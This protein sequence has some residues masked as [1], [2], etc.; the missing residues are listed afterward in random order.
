MAM[1]MAGGRLTT[2]HR[3]IRRRGVRMGIT[4]AHIVQCRAFDKFR[5]K[6]PSERRAHGH[7]H[8]HRAEATQPT[9]PWDHGLA[10]RTSPGMRCGATVRDLEVASRSGVVAASHQNERAEHLPHITAGAL[11]TSRRRKGRSVRWPVLL[12]SLQFPRC[13][14]GDRRLRASSQPRPR[15]RYR[16]CDK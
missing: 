16:Q 3:K 2:E 12:L 6:A 13:C 10:K 5:D 14:S 1:A 9:R 4:M 15:P 11:R 7:G 8:S